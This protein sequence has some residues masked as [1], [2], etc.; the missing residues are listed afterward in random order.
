[1]RYVSGC[2]IIHDPLKECVDI[3]WGYVDYFLYVCRRDDSR[4]VGVEFIYVVYVE[5]ELE[6]YDIVNCRR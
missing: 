6:V 5:E 3:W 2:V 1:M 4:R